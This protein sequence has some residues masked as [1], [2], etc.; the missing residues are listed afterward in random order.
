MHTKKLI[1]LSSD[2]KDPIYTTAKSYPCPAIHAMTLA[3]F[4]N[5]IEVDDKLNMST[6]I[7]RWRYQSNIITNDKNTLILNRLTE[8]PYHLTNQADSDDYDFLLSELFGYFGFAMDSFQQI[9]SLFNETGII[10]TYPLYH[11]WRRVKKSKI[12]IEL[13]QYFWGSGQFNTLPKKNRVAGNIFDI[14]NWHVSEEPQTNPVFYYTR[15]TGSPLFALCIKNQLLFTEYEG[16]DMPYNKHQISENVRKIKKLFG[17]TVCEI[18]LFIDNN[19]VSF[20]NI[21]PYILYSQHNPLLNEFITSTLFQ[22]Y[23]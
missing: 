20:A 5:D 10:I 7:I 11:Q 19:Q 9:E 16:S 23:L 4:I 3:D 21:S 22:D 8:I 6:S 18:L 14:T 12:D 17:Y 15:P 2:D 13:P 1:I